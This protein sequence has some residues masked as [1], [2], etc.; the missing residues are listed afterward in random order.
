MAKK[1]KT[2]RA[3]A[4][5]ARQARK[6][7][8]ERLEELGEE[9]GENTSVKESADSKAESKGGILKKSKE[10]ADAETKPAKASKE[11]KKAPKKKRFQF[12]YDVKSELKRVTWPSRVDVLRW[13]GVVVGALVFFGIFV[14]IL[15]N[16]I[17]T[18]L[19][20][21]LSGA[22]PSTID[23]FNVITGSDNSFVDSSSASS[24][25]DVSVDTTGTDA[26]GTDTVTVDTDAGADSVD[27][28]TE[29]ADAADSADT[30][31][32]GEAET[33]EGTE[34]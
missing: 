24:A 3:K 9:A 4:S 7:E 8:K 27:T 2:Q 34:E 16:L 21:L 23:W 1:S 13:S 32:G 12:L 18:P 25:S 14:A 19:L 5:A 28:G 11:E 30:Q 29:G 17:V 26:T 6:A 31:E 15:D 10:N 20:V 33:A 22:D